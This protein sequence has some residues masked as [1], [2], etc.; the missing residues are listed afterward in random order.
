[1]LFIKEPVW[2]TQPNAD[3]LANTA[4][5]SNPFFFCLLLILT[6]FSYFSSKC[7][8]TELQNETNY[9]KQ[10]DLEV[11]QYNSFLLEDAACPKN[12]K[13]HSSDS[14]CHNTPT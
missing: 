7:W 8:L 10:L 5:P 9:Y 14:Q 6:I 12:A 1:M 2:M 11:C 13:N 4:H 3:H